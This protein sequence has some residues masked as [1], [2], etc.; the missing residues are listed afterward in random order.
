MITC[1][2]LPIPNRQFFGKCHHPASAGSQLQIGWITSRI[3]PV[4]TGK[5]QH[6]VRIRTIMSVDQA[7]FGNAGVECQNLAHRPQA[8]HV[9]RVNWI[10]AVRISRHVGPGFHRMPVQHFT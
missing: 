10:G 3:A 6:K 2:C 9:P 5:N 4:V 7:D 1:A 8:N